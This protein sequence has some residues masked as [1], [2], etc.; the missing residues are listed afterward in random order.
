MTGNAGYDGTTSRRV[1]VDARRLW[2][3]GLATACVAALVAVVGVLIARDVLGFGL[4]D[5]AVVLSVGGSFTFDY[6]LTAFLLALVATALAHALSVSTPRPQAFFG[7]IIGLA[8]VA[9]T[10]V[11]FATEGSLGGQISVAMINLVIGLSIGSLLSTV[12]A[13]TVFDAEASW[14]Q[15]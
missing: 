5:S 11:P 14:Q 8:T 3:G 7:W 12:L 4:E 2:S 10:V 9:A 13:R 15:R 1:S 6:A